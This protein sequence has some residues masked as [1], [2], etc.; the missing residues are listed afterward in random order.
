MLLGVIVHN[1]QGNNPG[2]GHPSPS[3]QLQKVR[4]PFYFNFCFPQLSLSPELTSSFAR[5]P[6]TTFS[7]F[8]LLILKPHLIKPV[9][10]QCISRRPSTTIPLPSS[11][12][13]CV[14]F[15]ATKDPV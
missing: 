13:R 15:Q 11:S 1:T 10:P 7:S 6:A 3:L 14:R 2:P 12:T 8:S 4:A 5:S 9:H